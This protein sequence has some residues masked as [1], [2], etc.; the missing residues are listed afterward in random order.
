MKEHI[1]QLRPNVF[2]VTVLFIIDLDFLFSAQNLP[3]IV[4]SPLSSANVSMDKIA[5]LKLEEKVIQKTPLGEKESKEYDTMMGD[6]VSREITEEIDPETGEIVVKIV[7]KRHQVTKHEVR[8][9]H[10]ERSPDSF[11][12]LCVF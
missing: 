1:C 7:E 5:G 2:L 4:E 12:L 9:Q 3:Y 8:A 6:E 10:G 11:E